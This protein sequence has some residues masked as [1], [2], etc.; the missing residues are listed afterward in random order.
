MEFFEALEEFRSAKPLKVTVGEGTTMVE[1]Q[2]DY[3]H[4][5]WGVKKYTQ[6]SVQQWKDGQIIN[7]KFYYPS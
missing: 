4:K 7:E 6:V 2:Y 1:W 5:E 3:T